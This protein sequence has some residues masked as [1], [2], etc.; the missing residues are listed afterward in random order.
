M[1]FELYDNN[2]SS[3]IFNLINSTETIDYKRF[4]EIKYDHTFPKPFTYN[5]MNVNNLFDM[6]PEDY[7]DIKE[8]L[9]QI[10]DWDRKT[11]IESVGA[12]TYACL[13]YTSD[14][15]DE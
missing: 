11:D 2:R 7:P 9:I 15:A 14:A 3:R 8:L 1:N 13:L 10:Q 4:K 5:F 6:R 12:G